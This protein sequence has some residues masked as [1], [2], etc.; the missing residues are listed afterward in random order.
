MS[1]NFS[2]PFQIH[3]SKKIPLS[4][5]NQLEWK[6]N[7]KATT[8]RK[9]TKSKPEKNP[10]LTQEF[11]DRLAEL[12]KELRTYPSRLAD[13]V[14]LKSVEKPQEALIAQ[15]SVIQF[16]LAKKVFGAGHT[17]VTYAG[18]NHARGVRHI[19]FYAEGTTVLD[20]E[21]DYED[22]QFGSNF[23]FQNIDLY[24]P[25]EWEA[26]FLKLTDELRNYKAKRR[27]AFN[28][29]RVSARGRKLRGL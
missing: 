26:D 1:S 15:E 23:R 12:E 20:I 2:R 3:R 7:M 22:Q 24:L 17:D 21:G 18:S 19:R 4:A 27:T 10:A 11:P 13:E 25:G 6:G 29:K 8:L 28:K 9:P 16:R 5:R 14:A